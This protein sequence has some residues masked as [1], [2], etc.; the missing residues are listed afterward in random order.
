MAEHE[1]L[2]VLL[3]RPGKTGAKVTAKS[4]WTVADL[5]RELGESSDEVLVFIAER[6]DEDGDIDIEVL[7]VSKDKLLSEL[8]GKGKIL[9]LHC[10]HC[11]RVHVTVNYGPHQLEHRFAPSVRVRRVLKWSK[12]K[13]KLTDADAENLA[14]FLCGGNDKVVGSKHLGELTSGKSC[15]VCFSLGKEINPEGFA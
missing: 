3:D 2:Q 8:L 5:L 4:T 14:L 9:H 6:E 13:L 15:D 10:H 7:E 11:R 1:S 12:K